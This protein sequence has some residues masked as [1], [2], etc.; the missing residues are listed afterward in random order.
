M[1]GI[2]NESHEEMDSEIRPDN[3][4]PEE[5]VKKDLR[6]GKKNKIKLHK[7]CFDSVSSQ[8]GPNKCF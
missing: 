2:D 4:R 6:N 1:V 5:I 3:S 7:G 8:I